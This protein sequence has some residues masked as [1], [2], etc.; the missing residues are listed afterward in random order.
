MLVANSLILSS[1]L[2][3]DMDSKVCKRIMGKICFDESNF[4]NCEDSSVFRPIF[5]FFGESTLTKTPS[6]SQ[7]FT[8]T[9]VCT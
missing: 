4:H 6:V 8:E 3:Q 7:P 9:R 1:N 5:V 2:H